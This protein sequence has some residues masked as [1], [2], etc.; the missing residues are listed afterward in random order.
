MECKFYVYALLD[1]RKPGRFVYGDVEFEFEPFYIGKGAGYR[2]IRHI[3]YVKTKAKWGWQNKFKHSKI[4]KILA[5]GLE[6]QIVKLKEKLTHDEA[7]VLEMETIKSI[8]RFQLNGPLTNMTDGGEGTLG[9]SRSGVK[10]GMFG[11][12]GKDHPTFGKALNLGKKR[13]EEQKKAASKRQSGEK[14]CWFGKC[15]D[16][17]IAAAAIKNSRLWEITTPEGETIIVF[18]K[19]KWCKE[20]GFNPTNIGTKHKHFGYSFRRVKTDN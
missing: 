4:R 16:P 3:Q 5:E 13:T 18:N 14:N 2:A 10:N 9:V 6:P 7:M 12:K 8:G 19:A 15:N 1:P 17:M 20:K 11:V